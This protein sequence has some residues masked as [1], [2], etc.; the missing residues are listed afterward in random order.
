MSLNIGQLPIR[1][2]MLCEH[3][4]GVTIGN[5]PNIMTTGTQDGRIVLRVD[6]LS[7]RLCECCGTRSTFTVIQEYDDEGNEIV[8]DTGES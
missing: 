3:C 5:V 7:S 4:A 1:A 6:V 2:A 8:G